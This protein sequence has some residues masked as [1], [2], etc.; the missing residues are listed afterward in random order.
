MFSLRQ[1]SLVAVYLVLSNEFLPLFGFMSTHQ[2]RFA[3]R[4]KAARRSVVPVAMASSANDGFFERAMVSFALGV[5]LTTSTVSP[6]FAEAS[7]ESPAPTSVV[8]QGTAQTPQWDY[9]EF[10]KEVDQD[11]VKKVTFSS[12][13]KQ[14]I[15]IDTSGERHRVE[16]ISNDASLVGKLADHKVDVYVQPPSEMSNTPDLGAL[17]SLLL[18]ALLLA[19]LFALTRNRDGEEGGGMGGG[20]G[21]MGGGGMNPFQMGKTQAKLQ[22]EPDTG[23]T[24][25]DVAGCDGSKLELTEIVEFLKNPAKYDAVGAKAPR[26]VVMEGPPGTGK[27]LLA[28]AVAGEAGVPFIG[29]SGSEFVEMFVG[30]GA[31]RVRDLFALAKK[32]APSI[33]FIDEIDAVGKSRGMPGGGGGNDEREQTLNQILTEM[34]GFEGNSGVVV[35]AATNRAD[36]LDAALLRPGRF[37]RRVPVDLPDR[38]GREAILKVHAKGK[39]FDSTVKL[40][41]VAVRTTGFSG[42]SLANLLNE[43][44]IVTARRNKKMIG[45]SEIEFALD[46]LTVGMEKRTGMASGK[47]KELVA[48]HEAGHALMGALTPGFDE[49]GKVTIIPRSGG[50]GG[51]TLFLPSEDQQDSGLYSRDY[52]ESMLAVALGGRVAEEL[53][54]GEDEVTTGASGDLQR[55]ADIARKMVTQWGFAADELGWLAW[56]SPETGIYAPKMASEATERRIDVE[57]EKIVSKAYN[58]CKTALSDHRVLLEALTQTLVER[59]TIGTDEIKLLLQAY[60]KQEGSGDDASLPVAVEA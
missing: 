6:A 53:A 10:L 22:L 14:M 60:E 49:V 59:E 26:G 27:T 35:L 25:E 19:G 39:P 17:G 5:A 29:T 40:P 7:I 45:I 51:F 55:V 32:N 42:A 15:V 52:L 50:A 18:P 24:F 21:G 12:D 37:D 54:Y 36:V 47:R 46:R 3:S 30:V 41:E 11:L 28:R 34:D 1:T 23:V 48:Y 13:G 43:A 9:S 2:P 4:S 16:P 31:S 57:V 33:I 8:N 44:A 56:E 20:M 38:T 58:T